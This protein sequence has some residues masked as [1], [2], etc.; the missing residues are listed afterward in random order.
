[1]LTCLCDAFYGEVGIASARVLEH[2]GCAVEFVSEQTCCGQ[3]PYNAG[4]WNAARKIAEHCRSTLGIGGDIPVVTPS[5]S[6]AAMLR[7]G[8]R[9]LFDD[10]NGDNCYEL[11]EFLV[12]VLRM[13][14]WPGKHDKRIALHRACHGRGLG[15]TDEHARLLG[16]IDGLEIV[17]GTADDQCCGFGGAFSVSHPFVS[18][19]IGDAKLASFGDVDEIVTTDM[20]C[21]MHLQGLLGRQDRK[22]TIRHFAEV[23]ANSAQL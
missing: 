5:S 17:L 6:C 12:K 3:P 21:G 10:A 14:A 16:T 8:Y 7:E 18:S 15:L 2:A 11:G 13:D 9:H 1:M 22:P 19:S 4:D 20:G 23:L